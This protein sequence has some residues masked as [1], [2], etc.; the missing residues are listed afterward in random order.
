MESNIKLFKELI[1]SKLN[2]ITKSWSN[3]SLLSDS[4]NYTLLNCG[5]LARSII[6]LMGL[7]NL[8]K[9]YLE[10]VD[11]ACALEMIQ[12]YSLI[13]DDL[14]EMDNATF[15]RG[16]LTNHLVHGAGQAL[17]AG[18]ALLTESFKVITSSNLNSDIKL[19]LIDLFVQKAGT[20]GV[21]YGQ[22]LDIINEYQPFEEWND[23]EKVIKHKTCALFEIAFMSIG[24]IGSQDIQVIRKLEEIGYKTGLAFQ[25]KDDLNDELSSSSETGKDTGLDVN[26]NT[27]HKIFGIEKANEYIDELLT[28]IKEELK[29]IFNSDEIYCYL[30][31]IMK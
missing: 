19:E 18:D 9:D 14:P 27:Y 22:S 6:V 3:A 25:I 24:I 2:S 15:R 10:A 13:H 7:N 23:V 1:L 29:N 28:E 21:C 26:K 16:K 4:M 30:K 17:L 12:S 11:V 8:N 5:K 31:S 20:K